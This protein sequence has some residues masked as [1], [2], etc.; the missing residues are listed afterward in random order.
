MNEVD[1]AKMVSIPVLF[2]ILGGST[3]LPWLLKRLGKL[4]PLLS[5]LICLSAGA[6]MGIA[7]LHL[8]PET[9]E[10]WEGY[11]DDQHH[12]DAYNGG[13]PDDHDHSDHVHSIQRHVLK[14]LTTVARSGAHR[15]SESSG[16][17]KH[18]VL[19]EHGEHGHSHPYP[20]TEMIACLV[21]IA[22]V[23]VEST[24]VWY[25]QRE[26]TEGTAHGH[27]HCD[28]D[29]DGHDHSIELEN[30]AA[31]T[32]DTTDNSLAAQSVVGV[33]HSPKIHGRSVAP[34]SLDEYGSNDIM[35][36]TF[37][38]HAHESKSGSAGVVVHV[39]EHEEAPVAGSV[40]TPAV[41]SSA[42]TGD[43]KITTGVEQVTKEDHLVAK[44]EPYS[45]EDEDDSPRNHEEQTKRKIDAYVTAS[46][47]IIHSL[48]N[49]LALGADSSEPGQFWAFFG[50]SI[51][52]KLMDG[53][54]VGIPI[55]RAKFSLA[56]NAALVLAVAAS[57]PIGVVIGYTV[58]EA[59]S[60]NL[61]RAIL[62]SISAGSFIFVALF[63][64][65]PAA[66][67]AKSWLPLRFLAICAGFAGMAVVAKWT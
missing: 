56:I 20:Y 6:M 21:V 50:A 26:G 43:A 47:I 54:A 41:N 49:G 30:L 9:R 52:H 36:E 25:L 58:A 42:P 23:A 46:A 55:Y 17:Y 11:F 65:F 16:P 35:L 64:M 60:S 3:L 19:E 59:N 51:G 7:F 27:S 37:H 5:F 48:F 45:H 2:V 57:T 15:V 8:L 14:A 13:D 1:T 66:L 28:V 39:N 38:A 31:T 22:L 63:E 12:E 34:G 10:I 62:M 67:R 32:K 4:K 53:L 18:N 33:C 24:L 61:A 44:T 29:V 40:T